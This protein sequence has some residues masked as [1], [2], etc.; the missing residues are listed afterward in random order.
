MKLAKTWTHHSS[1]HRRMKTKCIF[2]QLSYHTLEHRG[3]GLGRVR[4]TH[5]QICIL[6]NI[7]QYLHLKLNFIVS[8][9]SHRVSPQVKH[10]DTRSMFNFSCIC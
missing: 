9:V 5:C 2:F 3:D 4:A 8:I 6:G 7:F 10:T 1:V